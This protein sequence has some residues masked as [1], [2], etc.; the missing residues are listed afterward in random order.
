MKTL[1]KISFLLFILLFITVK[2]FSQLDTLYSVFEFDS[3]SENDW[4]I[5]YDGKDLW[6]SDVENGTVYKT[7]TDGTLLDSMTVS[8]ALIK[9]IEIVDDTLW[10]LNSNFEGDIYHLYQMNM[11][12]GNINDT[13]IID[14]SY[15]NRDPG[16][17]WGLCYKSSKF[18]ISYNGGYGSCLLELDPIDQTQ[19]Y[20]CCTHL[21][22]M[23]SIEDSIWA[24]QGGWYI[25]TTDG[26]ETF[27]EYKTNIYAS[28]LVY[29]GNS[30]WVV[31]MNSDKIHQ[32]EPVTVSLNET[33]QN[34]R[35]FKIYPI[36]TSNY[37]QIKTD[38]IHIK[39]IE[40]FDMQG[41]KI[42]T[43]NL[44]KTMSDFKMDIS[45]VKTGTYI[46]ILNTETESF[47][48]KV[49]INNNR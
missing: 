31:N 15:S 26:H 38:P 34:S 13:I 9:G 1:R 8:G 3:P 35:V 42:K 43:I 10:V 14:F 29:D 25:V 7:T 44:N 23:T 27:Y 21:S 4:G 20:L 11:S 22:G 40:L 41:Q 49:M 33:K 17:L 32:L 45:N 39:S 16:M 2:S 30:F 48:E 47:K 46:L 28:D 37:L 24:I 12:N 6:I 5:A 36:P 18:Y 19:K